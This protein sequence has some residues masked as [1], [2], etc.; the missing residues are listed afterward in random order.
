MRPFGVAAA[1]VLPAALVTAAPAVV[2]SP[3]PASAAQETGSL[4]GVAWHD[5]N[6]DGQIQEGEPRL[7]GVA[8]DTCCN[9][10]LP[11]TVHT[12]ADGSYFIDDV[13]V[14]EYGLHFELREGMTFS[15]PGIGDERT[16]SDMIDFDDGRAEAEVSV[17]RPGVLPASGINAGY[18]TAPCTGLNERRAGRIP[19]RTRPAHPEVT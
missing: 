6:A 10:A 16:N 7:A 13:P 12:A 14:A 9:G 2:G 4:S 15:P 18:V 5:L 3:L 19:P 8:I 1:L 11:Q 17:G